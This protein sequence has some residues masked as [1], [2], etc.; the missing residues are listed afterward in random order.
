MNG[1][2]ERTTTP[3]DALNVN[4]RFGISNVDFLIEEGKSRTIIKK[5]NRRKSGEYG[6]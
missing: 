5:P 2:L 1:F 3:K 4:R 6:V